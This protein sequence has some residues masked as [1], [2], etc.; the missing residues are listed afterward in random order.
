MKQREQHSKNQKWFILILGTLTNTLVFAVPG[1]SL[2]V[3]LPA[4][5]EELNLS[6]FQ[7]GLA[8]GIASLPTIVSFL[9]AGSFID[10]Y[11]PR[12]ALI[13][14]CIL[15]GLLG[16]SR[17]LATSFPLLLLTIALTGFVNPFINLSSIKNIS[18]WFPSEQMGLANGMLSLGMAVGFFAGSIVS[19]NF[20]A[21]WVGGWRN[22]FFFYGLVSFLFFLPWLFTPKAPPAKSTP[23]TPDQAPTMWESLKHITTIKNVWLLGL[24]LFCFNGAVQGFLGYLP[25]YLRNLGWEAIRSD[26]L[27]ASFHLASLTFTIPIAI[28]SDRLKSRKG[29]AM[30][31]AALTTLGILSFFV[32]RGESLWG[33]VIAA[34]LARDGMMAILIT[35]TVEMKGVGDAYAGMATGFI[36]IF[37]SLGALISPPVG[38]QLSVLLPNLP[39]LFWGSLCLCTVI[40]LGFLS[41]NPS[42]EDQ[43]MLPLS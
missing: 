11:G 21:P 6:L 32:L 41:K 33:A 39:F 37:A 36:F 16:A 30:G 29:I 35:M 12:R 19:A 26:S 43:E 10:R 31:A 8:W 3:L 24:A 28:L 1:I 22:T 13:L 15:S 5:T 2:S 34:G 25:L 20:I 42:P 27:A 38:N 23:Q 7:A 17:G 9:I 4:I 18:R 40:L 14:M